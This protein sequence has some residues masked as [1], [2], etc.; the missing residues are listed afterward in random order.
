MSY[1]SK[2][3][4]GVVNTSFCNYRNWH[5]FPWSSTA[6]SRSLTT[7]GKRLRR[8]WNR[9]GFWFWYSPV[10]QPLPLSWNYFDLWSNGISFINKKCFDKGLILNMS[11]TDRVSIKKFSNRTY[12]SP[13]YLLMS[14]R[15]VHVLKNTTR[16]THKSTTLKSFVMYCIY[17][18]EG[19]NVDWLFMSFFNRFKFKNFLVEITI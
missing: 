5:H 1:G 8:W 2:R 10:L 12:N 11:I 18:N 6:V 15:Y 13:T 19:S 9:N 14:N 4:P 3:R 16:I 17:G 7:Q